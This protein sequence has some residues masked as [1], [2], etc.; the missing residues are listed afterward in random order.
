M[1]LNKEYIIRTLEEERLWKE[2]ET[3]IFKYNNWNITLRKEEKIYNPFTFSIHGEKD[4]SNETKSRR[5]ISMEEAFL[6][7]LNKFNENVN[8]KN[9][10]KT[11]S[12]YIKIA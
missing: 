11:M 12:D 3:D 4:N 5:Y 6:H 10:Y 9:N 1:E 2:G 7:V 8:I